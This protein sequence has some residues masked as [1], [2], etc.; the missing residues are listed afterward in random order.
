M[1]KDLQRLSV[2]TSRSYVYNWSF[3]IDY[4]EE[5]GD[6]PEDVIAKICQIGLIFFR[7]TIV[8]WNTGEYFPN[9]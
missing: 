7:I 8:Y 2:S 6:T 9:D 1:R 5:Y 3:G 4:Y